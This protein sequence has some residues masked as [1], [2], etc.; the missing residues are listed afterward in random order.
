MPAAPAPES[1]EA[2]RDRFVR[3]ALPHLDA[4]FRTAL[5]MTGDRDRAEEA[6]QETY[7]RAWRY[8]DSFGEGRDARVWLFAILRNA[9]YESA[10]RRRRELQAASLDEIGADAA[11]PASGASGRAPEARLFSRE[12]LAEIEKL[13]EEYRLV[14][15]MAVVEEMKYREIADALDIP[16]GTVMSRLYRGRRLLQ[17]RLRAYVE[18]GEGGEQV[19]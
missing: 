12:I 11:A 1:Q 2:R 8:F 18:Q 3:L 4:L 6:V 19:A 10:R 14:V 16:I 5:Y 13:P 7:L 17:M 15:L 9:I